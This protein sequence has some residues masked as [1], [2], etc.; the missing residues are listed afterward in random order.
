M[1]WQT[2]FLPCLRD[3]VQILHIKIGQTEVYVSMQAS[4]LAVEPSVDQLGNELASEGDNEGVGYN[5]DP[6]Q[7]LHDIKPGI[8]LAVSV[9]IM[10]GN[11]NKK[12][13]SY[14]TPML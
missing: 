5:R 2:S 13:L 6:P 10:G 8:Y 11:S 14:H 4:I 7:S 1:S 9:E 12:S 3:R